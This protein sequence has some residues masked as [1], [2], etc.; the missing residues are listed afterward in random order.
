MIL[1]FCVSE[2]LVPNHPKYSILIGNVALFFQ[3]P[4]SLDWLIPKL[5]V[6][7]S[8]FCS[9]G[10]TFSS[11][12]A[13]NQRF[14]FSWLASLPSA[15]SISAWLADNLIFFA[16]M[17]PEFLTCKLKAVEIFPAA[18]VLTA[19]VM[20]GRNCFLQKYIDK[21]KER[22]DT[23]KAIRAMMLSNMCFSPFLT[24]KITS[25]SGGF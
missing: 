7:N 3:N 14:L 5:Q 22:M 19:S 17:E 2:Y 20:I 23:T 12:K 18:A 8:P 4:L 6:I 9:A 1:T 10:I 24:I 21:P 25:S 13:A 15:F 16:G 11:S